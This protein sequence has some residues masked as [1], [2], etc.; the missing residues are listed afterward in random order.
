HVEGRRFLDELLIGARPLGLEALADAAVGIV[1]LRALHL[2]AMA[3]LAALL[4]GAAER[5]H[6]R[7][8][9]HRGVGG[10]GEGVIEAAQVDGDGVA[11]GEQLLETVAGAGADTLEHVERAAVL[12]L[13]GVE[14]LEALGR[15]VEVLLR[16]R[17]ATVERSERT[18]RARMCDAQ[19][20]LLIA[21][22]FPRGLALRERLRGLLPLEAMLA[23]PLLERG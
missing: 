13:L 11:L 22:L 19:L 23:E 4:G 21:H 2:E 6:L 9:R 8:E 17:E 10:F 14:L 1:G 15:A 20:R 7:L 16:L 5:A 3:E 18:L 12:L